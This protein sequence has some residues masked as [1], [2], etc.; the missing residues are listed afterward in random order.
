[1]DCF[2]HPTYREGFGMVLQEAGAM[3]LPIIT[4]RIPGASEVMENGVSS[5]HVKEKD[6]EALKS[7]MKSFIEHQDKIIRYG[8]AAYERT[9]RFYDRKIMLKNQREDY[10]Q[11]LER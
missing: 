9:R 1:M 2:V 5:V 4:T 7:V 11:L 6:V 10:Q 8:K 3:G